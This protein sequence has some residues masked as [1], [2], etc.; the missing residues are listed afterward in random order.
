MKGS[1]CVYNKIT[2]NQN[3]KVYT[4][5][6][7]KTSTFYPFL[8]VLG[9]M[10]CASFAARRGRNSQRNTSKTNMKCRFVSFRNR[11]AAMK[12]VGEAPC[13]LVIR[14]YIVALV[15]MELI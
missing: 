4:T 1:N 11:K 5:Y 15:D 9:A 10:T 8:K 6:N 3:L 14:L 13:K 2:L 12:Y 7:T